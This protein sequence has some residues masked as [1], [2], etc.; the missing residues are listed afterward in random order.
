MKGEYPLKGIS[1]YKDNIEMYLK[2]AG[3][4]DQKGMK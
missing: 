1:L 4:S 3:Y 2:S